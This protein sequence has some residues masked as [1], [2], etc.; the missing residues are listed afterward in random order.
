MNLFANRRRLLTV[1]GVG[2]LVVAIAAVI[3]YGYQRY[4]S[5]VR[6]SA[7]ANHRL[8]IEEHQIAG[9]G[10]VLVSN[11]GYAL[12]VFAPDRGRAVTC[13]GG[14]ADG[15]P[16]VTASSGV[17]PVAGNGVRSSLLGTV[18]APGGG[19]V[20]S[21]RGWPLYTYLGDADPLRAAGQAVD[22]DGGFW[23]LIRPS[24][25]IVTRQAGAP[26]AT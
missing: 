5:V 17:T 2:A 14:C 15:W 26:A 3:G 23:Y 1:T 21:Y 12:Y 20:V 8:V 4:V 16:P 7:T 6:Y 24:G 25:Q 10:M 19:R 11:K 22:D 9:L 13:T 18:A